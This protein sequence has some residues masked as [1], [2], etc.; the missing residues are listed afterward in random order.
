MSTALFP[1]STLGRVRTCAT[2]IPSLIAL[3]DTPVARASTETA[4]KEQTLSRRDS[5]HSA[6]AAGYPSEKPGFD[7]MIH[8]TYTAARTHSLHGS[9]KSK[10]HL[11]ELIVSPI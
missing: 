9:I 4:A 5:H 8:Q 11:T 3:R 7:S 6:Q 2:F 1:A 10:G